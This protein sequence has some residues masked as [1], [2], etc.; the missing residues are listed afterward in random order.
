MNILL[1]RLA[2]ILDGALLLSPI[3]SQSTAMRVGLEL[4]THTFDG[5]TIRRIAP[6]A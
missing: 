2:D 1:C 3:P 4:G 5:I 6:F